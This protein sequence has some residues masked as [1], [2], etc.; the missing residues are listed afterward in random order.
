MREL[1]AWRK[2]HIEV[3]ATDAYDFA[4][5]YCFGR[6]VFRGQ[7]KTGADFAYKQLTRIRAGE[8][9]YP[10]LMA[11]EGALA[12]VPEECHGLYVSP[13]FPVFTIHKDR[14]LPEVLDVYFR[15]PSV[16][17]LLGGA[18]TGTNVRR[19]RLNPRDFLNYSFPLPTREAQLLLQN[20]RRK[21]TDLSFLSNQSAQ[22]SA[23]MPSVLDRAFKGGL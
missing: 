21:V 15:S 22:L 9:I 6:G 4:G 8:F 2:P 7:R 20:I 11:W 1:V 14:V 18:S 16:W 13:E 5:V 10:K 3:V 12:V 19:K 17:P 23:L